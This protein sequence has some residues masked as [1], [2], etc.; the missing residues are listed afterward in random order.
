MMRAVGRTGN[1]IE[2]GASVNLIGSRGPRG[3]RVPLRTNEEN[4][5]GILAIETVAEKA[6]STEIERGTKLVATGTT[7]A[8][9]NAGKILI[10][11]GDTAGTVHMT[12]TN[13]DTGT[14]RI[15]DDMAGRGVEAA[16]RA[17]LE[18]KG[19]WWARNLM[20]IQAYS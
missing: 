15:G 10:G 9:A 2:T 6:V 8:K 1:I 17:L 4:A 13:A 12:V 20:L 11:I 16:R 5:A 3:T 18:I 19:A 14:W 7:E